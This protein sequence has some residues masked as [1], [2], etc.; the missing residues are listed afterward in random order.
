M[1]SFS[2]GSSVFDLEVEAHDFGSPPQSSVV[3]VRIEVMTVMAV[4]LSCVF[5]KF[6]TA[7]RTFVLKPEELFPFVAIRISLVKIAANLRT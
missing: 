2:P 1:L 7:I 6:L 4:F 3:P 5:V